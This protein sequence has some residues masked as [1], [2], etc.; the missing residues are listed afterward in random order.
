MGIVFS[1]TGAV[2]N[3]GFSCCET[4]GSAV[5]GCVGGVFGAVRGLVV[6]VFTTL[7]RLLPC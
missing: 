2:V 6:G 5:M 4:C 3:E 7:G 1:A